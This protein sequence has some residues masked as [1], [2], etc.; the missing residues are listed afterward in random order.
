MAAEGPTASQTPASLASGTTPDD[1]A[2]VL[3]SSSLLFGEDVETAVVMAVRRKP[4]VDR[5]EMC[6]NS[7][8][9]S[10]DARCTMHHQNCAY[11]R[12]IWNEQ[13]VGNEVFCLF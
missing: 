2:F 11:A 10:P 8:R 4:F 7:G 1:S 9:Y 6:A 12:V 13:L 5:Y 3:R